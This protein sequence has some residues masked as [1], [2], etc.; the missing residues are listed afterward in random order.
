MKDTSCEERSARDRS[1]PDLEAAAEEA[2]R[3]WLAALEL[4]RSERGSV[5]PPRRWMERLPEDA[6]EYVSEAERRYLDARD[7]W[8][9]VRDRW[10]VGW[11]RE[12][13]PAP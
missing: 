5:I 13:R 7:A 2:E 8:W 12:P 10:L 4:W 1:G 6:P 9:D 3:G 11:D